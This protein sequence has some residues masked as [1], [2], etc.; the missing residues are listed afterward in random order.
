MLKLISPEAMSRIVH[1]I[2]K[3]KKLG[4][5]DIETQWTILKVRPNVGMVSKPPFWKMAA[6]IHFVL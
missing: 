2:G 6:K 3:S 5:G 4:G 1:F